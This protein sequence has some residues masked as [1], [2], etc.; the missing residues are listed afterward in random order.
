[1]PTP[2]S[3][4]HLDGVDGST[5]V[6]NDV[7]GGAAVAWAF[8][9][10][11]ALTTVDPY[12]GAAMA[13][14]TP[15][16]SLSSAAVSPTGDWTLAFRIGL[17][18]ASG[19]QAIIVSQGRPGDAG[20]WMLEMATGSLSLSS[21]LGGRYL[22][23]D[24]SPRGGAAAANRKILAGNAFMC[25]Q[26]IRGMLSVGLA[27][28]GETNVALILEGWMPYGSPASGSLRFNGALF[29]GRTSTSYGGTA[30]IDEVVYQD[31][32]AIWST[33]PFVKPVGAHSFAGYAT[34]VPAGVRVVGSVGA[35]RAAE[36]AWAV[37][38]GLA[39]VG[40]AGAVSV[41]CNGGATPMGVAGT[42]SLGRVDV[43]AEV[44]VVT[45]SVDARAFIGQALG[46]GDATT[47]VK[48]VHGLGFV[49]SLS[50]EI[51]DPVDI[52]PS[53]WIRYVIPAERR[54]FT[55]APEARI[56]TTRKP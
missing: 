26:C 51:V 38:A 5:T 8:E 23:I 48:G 53:T 49:G 11:G 16:Q 10:G 41:R 43:G 20:S 39:G 2:R 37:P 42:S 3:L 34:A 56:W 17:T 4:L 18:P 35:A 14:L 21:T 32:H 50:V 44:L 40:A 55:L 29:P 36:L 6:A 45:P 54:F 46:A 1:M 31:G 25:V 22:E 7:T 13:S 15:A 27:G 9:G 33:Y 19:G 12:L 30:R 47:M 52:G 24:A 28:A